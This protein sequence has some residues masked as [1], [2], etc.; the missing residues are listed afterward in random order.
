MTSLMVTSDGTYWIWQESWLLPG[1]DPSETPGTVQAVCR[2]LE[3][4]Q[5]PT[6]RWVIIGRMV[7]HW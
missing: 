4:E 6:G 7:T 2:D 3:R 5:G 1:R